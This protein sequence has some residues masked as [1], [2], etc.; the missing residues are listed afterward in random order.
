MTKDLG[1]HGNLFG[2]IMCSWIDESAA[3]YACTYCDTSQIVTVKI[4]ELVFKKAVKQ[5]QILR[6]YGEVLSIGETSISLHII[7]KHHDPKTEEETIVTHTDIVFVRIDETGK[8]VPI[9]N[10]IKEKFKQSNTLR[11]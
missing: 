3:L 2:G 7:V 11:K 10:S 9:N 4:S 6:F 5:G 8:A 1:V